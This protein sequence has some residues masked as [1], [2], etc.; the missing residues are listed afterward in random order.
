VSSC[1]QPRLWPVALTGILL[2]VGPA[3]GGPLEPQDILSVDVTILPAVVAPGDSV[4]V[5]LIISNATTR[6]IRLSSGDSCVALPEVYSAGDRVNWSGTGLGC[7]TVVSA[8]TVPAGGALTRTFPLVAL[9]QESGA[10]WD[11]TVRPPPGRHAVVMRMHV[12]QLSDVHRD[13]MVT[14]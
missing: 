13:L 4:L 6:P 3:C 10:P 7:L 2:S 14:E 9:L 1:S 12:A 5:T 8:F 11:Y